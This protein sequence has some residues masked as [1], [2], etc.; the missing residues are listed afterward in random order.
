MQ[1]L[2]PF[3]FNTWIANIGQQV[4]WQR[5]Y[6]CPC[7]DPHSGAARF[8]CKQCS[9]SGYVWNAPKAGN[10]GISGQKTQQAWASMGRYENGDV[11][12]TLPSDTPLYAMGENDRIVFGQ[13]SHPFSLATTLEKG[14]LFQPSQID[15]VFWL[16][17]QQNLVEGSLPTANAHGQLT[18]D[19][20]P[21]SAPGQSFS[22][23]GRRRPEYFCFLDYPQD[24]H[25]HNGLDL[26]RRIVLRNF[27][28]FHRN[29][30]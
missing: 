14:L 24:R 13:S 10:L 27:D 16:D 18:F 4:S 15:R 6:F 22:I 30:P 8:D 1:Q 5:A 7:R 9:G 21:A 28:L 17:D 12:C 2:S 19:N 3:A 29:L 20:A 25:H 11:V 26:P 23:T